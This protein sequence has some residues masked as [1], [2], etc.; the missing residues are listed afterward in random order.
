MKKK[1]PRKKRRHVNKYEHLA[2]KGKQYSARDKTF[3]TLPVAGDPGEEIEK[4]TRVLFHG[5]IY[6]LRASVTLP[7]S[8]STYAPFK[9]VGFM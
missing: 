9:L 7:A 2:P 4:G 3:R 6:A 8:G 1:K 5:R